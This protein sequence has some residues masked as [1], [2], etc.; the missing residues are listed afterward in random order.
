[1]TT[2]ERIALMRAEEQIAKPGREIIRNPAYRDRPKP[3][4][5]HL[6]KPP[7][8]ECGR[9]RLCTKR[10][11]QR[12][13]RAEIRISPRPCSVP[14]C[15]TRVF[16]GD[17]CGRHNWQMANFGQVLPN[18]LRVASPQMVERARRKLAERGI[19]A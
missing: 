2:L 14:G 19:A 13:R 18:T 15:S 11:W 6:R 4:T 9:C 10:E 8:C 17:L 7:S 12:K 1:M 16:K 5:A 3:K